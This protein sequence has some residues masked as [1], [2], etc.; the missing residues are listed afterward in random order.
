MKAA[1]GR[2]DRII[3]ELLDFSLARSGAG[4]P[5]APEAGDLHRTVRAYMRE[6]EVAY[7]RRALKLSQDGSGEGTFDPDRI[8]QVISNLVS[9]AVAYGHVEQPIEI[10][11]RSEGDELIVEVGNANDK[12]PIPPELAHVLFDPFRRGAQRA[13]ARGRSVGLG[14]YIVA[15]IAKAHGGKVEL[16]S[17]DARTTFTLRIPRLAPSLRARFR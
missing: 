2:A 1:A 3:R 11:S 12:G 6:A 13:G 5:I 15:E 8:T 10:A 4:I 14:L 16:T 9:N 7:P 17:S